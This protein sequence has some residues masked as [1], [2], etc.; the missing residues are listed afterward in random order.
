MRLPRESN[1]LGS[2]RDQV[3]P[4]CSAARRSRI[5]HTRPGS[6]PPRAVTLDQNPGHVLTGPCGIAPTAETAPPSSPKGERGLECSTLESWQRAY[7]SRIGGPIS[8]RIDGRSRSVSPGDPTPTDAACKGLQRFDKTTNA[9]PPPPAGAG[10]ACLSPV[11][12]IFS[13]CFSASL[14]RARAHRHVGAHRG[15][16]ASSHSRRRGSAPRR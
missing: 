9:R 12:A 1:Q 2:E 7:G 8:P 5:D 11:S 15:R 10:Q 6:R 13:G 4:Y 14:E 16:S 3:H